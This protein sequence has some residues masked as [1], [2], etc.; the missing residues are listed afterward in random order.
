MAR[1]SQGSAGYALALQFAAQGFRVFATARSLKTLSNLAEA[2]IEILTLD[3]T[4]PE[5]IAAVKSQI[6]SRTGG[7]L[8]ILF[9]NAGACGSTT[10]AFTLHLLTFVVNS[11]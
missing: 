8:D 7:S 11:V 4:Q 3:V 10:L 9:N 1:C 6:A 5:S 2:G